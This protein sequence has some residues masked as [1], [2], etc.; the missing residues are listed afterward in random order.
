LKRVIVVKQE[1]FGAGWPLFFGEEGL[2]Y[3]V[4]RDAVRYNYVNLKL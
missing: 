4:G 1:G 3:E 2:V